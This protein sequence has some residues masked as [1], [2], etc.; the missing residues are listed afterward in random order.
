MSIISMIKTK[1]RLQKNKQKAEL[2]RRY[3]EIRG[4][5]IKFY[6][7]KDITEGEVINIPAFM[8][9]DDILKKVIKNAKDI[10]FYYAKLLKYRRVAA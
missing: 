10:N 8:R 7:D 1:S 2:R 3:D 9:A 4:E 6:E 5:I